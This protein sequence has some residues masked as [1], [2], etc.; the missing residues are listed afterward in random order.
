MPAHGPRAGEGL[1]GGIEGVEA[2]VAAS[3]RGPL[4][5]PLR[6]GAKQVDGNESAKSPG[7]SRR[8]SAV[9]ISGRATGRMPG[10][11]EESGRRKENEWRD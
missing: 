1:G 2:I 11:W 7:K 10:R 3:G 5:A 9:T 4:A 8:Q 6:P